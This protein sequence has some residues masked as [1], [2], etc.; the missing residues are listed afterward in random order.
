MGGRVTIPTRVVGL[1]FERGRECNYSNEGGRAYL[2][3]GGRAKF[4]RRDGGQLFERGREGN[5][6]N[7]KGRSN[8]QK[9][10]REGKYL[11]D[12]LRAS[13]KTRDGGQI[14]FTLSSTC[15]DGSC[16]VED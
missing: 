4:C 1:V 5:Y 12:G 11:N 8:I 9:R 15:G 7:E 16:E 10:E 13:I 14:S 3:E 6:S 2:F